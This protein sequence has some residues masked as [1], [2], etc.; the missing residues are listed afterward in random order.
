[1]ATKYWRLKVKGD[2]S[3]DE[4]H[5]GVGKGGGLVLRV[6]REKGET[7]VYYAGEDAQESH[8]LA[9]AGR[10]ESVKL[11]DVSKI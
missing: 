6:H 3:A 5:R 7:H 9:G 11:D 1:M 4:I 2:P 10:P 8:G